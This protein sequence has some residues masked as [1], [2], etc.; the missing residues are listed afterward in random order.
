MRAAAQKLKRP[1]SSP[2]RQPYS[3]PE[4]SENRALSEQVYYN[5]LS[6]GTSDDDP[7]A[8]SPV[9]SVPGAG[10]EGVVE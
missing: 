2:A 9:I 6:L 7:V 5:I 3:W 4:P 1:H 8:I 10:F